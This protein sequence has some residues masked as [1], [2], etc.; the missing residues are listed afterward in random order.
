MII[1]IND[2]KTKNLWIEE[3]IKAS[4]KQWKAMESQQLK[5][6]IFTKELEFF[7]Q[8]IIAPKI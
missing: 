8:R 1:Q 7:K 4:L 2:K 5:A 6:L 3:K